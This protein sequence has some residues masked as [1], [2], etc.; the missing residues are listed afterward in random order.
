ME[1]V[2]GTKYEVNIGGTIYPWGEGTITPSQIRVLGGFP[3]NQ[4]VIEVDL[5]T[6]VE[7]TLQEDAIVH[8]KPGQGFA[9]K[10]EFKRGRN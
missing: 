4:P 5:E 10:I 7:T 9:K 1:D 8:L 3:T 6:N 2:R